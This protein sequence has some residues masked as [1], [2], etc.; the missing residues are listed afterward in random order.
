MS[1]AVLHPLRP[2]RSCERPSLVQPAKL[3]DRPATRTREASTSGRSVSRGSRGTDAV[4]RTGRAPARSAPTT[5]NCSR[6]RCT[7]PPCI[8]STATPREYPTATEALSIFPIGKVD[9]CAMART[10]EA[11]QGAADGDRGRRDFAARAAS[12]YRPSATATCRRSGRRAR[13][14]P[15]PARRRRGAPATSATPKRRREPPVS[16]TIYMDPGDTIE[17]RHE[18][19]RQAARQRWPELPGRRP[20]NPLRLHRRPRQRPTVQARRHVVFAQGVAL[21]Q[22]GEGHRRLL[23]HRH[24][25]RLLR[26]DREPRHRRRTRRTGSGTRTPGTRTR[27]GAPRLRRQPATPHPGLCDFNNDWQM[28]TVREAARLIL[29]HG[30]TLQNQDGHLLVEIPDQ[31]D[32][33]GNLHLEA[34]KHVVR[35]ARVLDAA[36]SVVL[37]EL[38][39]VEANQASRRAAPR[40]ARSRLRW[41]RMSDQ[42]RIRPGS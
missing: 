23:Q 16:S 7:E 33:N 14:A 17:A 19:R 32:P 9:L 6:T 8:G 5:S 10:K 26:A 28:P 34:M 37:D 13:P 27:T 1:P 35:A 22:R 20:R 29:D 42:I 31:L 39:K 41:C 21:R 38:A 18:Q 15:L 11:F 40:P 4:S 12:I 36:G 2:N 24:R 30:C 25:T 3:I